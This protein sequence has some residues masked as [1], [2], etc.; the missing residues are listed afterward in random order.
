VLIP[1]PINRLSI[2]LVKSA[3]FFVVNVV[4]GTAIYAL[5]WII[6]PALKLDNIFNVIGIIAT[7]IIGITFMGR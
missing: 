2:L 1:I 5:N 3:H 6:F 4:K 7:P